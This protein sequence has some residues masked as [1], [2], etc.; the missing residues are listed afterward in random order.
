M[1]QFVEREL[2]RETKI[3]GEKMSQCYFVHHKNT[4]DLF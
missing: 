1:E 4:Y 3:F 2:A